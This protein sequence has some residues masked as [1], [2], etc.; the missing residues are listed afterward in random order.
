MVTANRFRPLVLLF[1]LL[2]V[3]CGL[4]MS[5]IIVVNLALNLRAYDKVSQEIRAAEEV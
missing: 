5:A 1:P 3:I 2:H 4:W